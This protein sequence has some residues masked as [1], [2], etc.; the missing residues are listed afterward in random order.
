[1][2]DP[3]KGN[4]SKDC[5]LFFSEGRHYA[6]H[7]FIQLVDKQTYFF[8]QCSVWQPFAGPLQIQGTDVNEDHYLLSCMMFLI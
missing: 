6:C 4:I 3:W 1:V 5:S 8:S 2:L 7:P